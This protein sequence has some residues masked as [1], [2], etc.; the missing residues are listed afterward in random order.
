MGIHDLLELNYKK[1]IESV[2]Q[3]DQKQIH[4]NA[5]ITAS[6]ME[7]IIG[8]NYEG[9]RDLNKA[10]FRK[11]VR[12]MNL[13]RWVLHPEPLVFVKTESGWIMTNGQHRSNAQIE[14]GMTIPYAICIRKDKDIYKYLDQGKVRSNA[15]ITGAHNGVV[16]PI[17]FLLRSASSISHPTPEDV[18]RVLDD[19]IGG[20]LSEIEYDIKPPKTSRGIWKQTGFRAAY[21]MAIAT[22]R[23]DHESALNIYKSLCRNEINE[24]PVIFI[25]MYRQIMEGQIHI[26]RAGVSLDNDYFMRGM[27]AFQNYNSQSKNVAIFSSFRNQVKE[28]VYGVMKK[29]A[30]EELRVVK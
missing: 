9:N 7:S 29:Y 19:S 21:A 17:Q 2:N 4:F 20:L 16:H 23:I 10:T 28:S 8:W 24:W 5:E 30:T 27:F 15:D 13:N 25:A 3:L 14:T 1:M 26:N 12:S 11:Y 6:E 22:N 18:S